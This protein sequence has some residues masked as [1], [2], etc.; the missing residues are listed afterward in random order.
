MVLYC[1]KWT[2]TIMCL[3][4]MQISFLIKLYYLHYMYIFNHINAKYFHNICVVT[5]T[6][7]IQKEH[8]QIET[9]FHNCVKMS[10]KYFQVVFYIRSWSFVTSWNFGRKVQI[11]NLVQIGPS[12]GCSKGYEMQ[13]FKMICIF[14]LEIWSLNFDQKRRW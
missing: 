14:H 3:H 13:I 1:I 7:V 12:L 9:H 2:Y 10:L 5:L 6:L 4:G 8:F 11:E